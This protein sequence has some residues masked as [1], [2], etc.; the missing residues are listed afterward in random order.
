MDA[1]GPLHSA[2]YLAVKHAE[3]EAFAAHDTAWECFH[4]F[5]KF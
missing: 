3:V 4:H 2:A 1:L 5:T